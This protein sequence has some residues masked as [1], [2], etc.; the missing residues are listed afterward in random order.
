MTTQK[1]PVEKLS[2]Q[3]MYHVSSIVAKSGVSSSIANQ[4]QNR[5]HYRYGISHRWE[6]TKDFPVFF[7]NPEQ[8]TNGENDETKAGN[9]VGGRG[10]KP[11]RRMVV[12]TNVVIFGQNLDQVF[13]YIDIF[14]RAMGMVSGSDIYDRPFNLQD[15]NGVEAAI[16]PNQN[17]ENNVNVCGVKAEFNVEF[18]YFPK[19]YNKLNLVTIHSGTLNVGL[20]GSSPAYNEIKL[21]NT[22]SDRPYV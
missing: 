14:G 16:T 5:S 8:I 9:W 20:S 3:L 4:L 6:E 11:Q 2:D 18:S 17:S 21:L 13:S 7:I 10:T 15:I 1:D 22:G 12:D 19:T